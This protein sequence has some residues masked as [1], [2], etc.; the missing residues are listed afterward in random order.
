MRGGGDVHALTTHTPGVNRIA[1][2]AASGASNIQAEGGKE[3]SSDPPC[4]CSRLS[5]SSCRV[6]AEGLWPS[7]SAS[8]EVALRPVSPVPLHGAPGG[9]KLTTKSCW[10][11]RGPHHALAWGAARGGAVARP[12]APSS[13]SSPVARKLRLEGGTPS[14]SL[15]RNVSKGI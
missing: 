15:R 8:T 6:S 2:A 11:A 4:M 5:S 10:E 13:A 7:A 1:S 14:D 9:P 3:L 12:R